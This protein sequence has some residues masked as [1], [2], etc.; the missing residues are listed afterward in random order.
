M[1]TAVKTKKTSVTFPFKLP[2][3]PP[4]EPGERLSRN[5][6]ERRYAAIPHL[7]KAE[8]VEGVVYVLPP[9]RFLSHGRPHAQVVCWLGVYCAGRDGVSAG[10]NA[11]VR[12]DADNEVQPDALLRWDES[13][14]G[15][16]RIT[17]DDYLEG[18]PELIV[19]I[20]ASSA[21]YDLYEKKTVYRRNGVQEYV[22]WQIYDGRLDWFWLDEGVYK[23]LAPDENGIIASRV[24]P[25][26]RLDV[27]AL[28]RHDMTAVLQ[29]LQ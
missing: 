27:S 21:S 18:P 24:F 23:T 15:R 2:A 28:L 7:K 4:L 10:S 29:A 22:V 12:L 19:E 9:V 14:G 11:T 20:A 16:S 8:L 17:D 13:K 25:G 6:F 3:I 1:N 5:E 26:L